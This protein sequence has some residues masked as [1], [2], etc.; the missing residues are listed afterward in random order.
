[1]ERTPKSTRLAYQPALD[2]LRAVAVTMV[3]LFHGGVSWMRGGYFGVSMFFTLSG[4]LITSLLVREFSATQRI[5]PGAFYVRRAKRLLPASTICIVVVSMMAA[6]DVWR[7]ADHIRRDAVGALFQVANWVQ[8]GGGGSYTDLQSKSAGLVSPLD[9]YWSLAI[10][11]QFYWIWPLAF[12]GLAAFARRRGV[13]LT[14]IM[15]ALTAVFAAAA[16]VVAWRWGRDAAYW[17]TPARAAEILIGALLAVAL[18]DGKVTPRRWMAPASLLAVALIAVLLPAAGGPAYHGAFPLLAIAS[19]GLV[20]GV[21][22]PGPVTRALSFKPLIAL[23]AISY[24]VYLYHF[25]I[26]VFLSVARVG[27]SGWVLLAARL[28]V[29]LVFAIASYWLVERP[30]RRAVWTGSRTMMHAAVAIGLVA[31]AILFV[32]T[33]N[34]TYWTAGASAIAAAEIPATGSV[35]PLAAVGP[36]ASGASRLPSSPGLPSASNASSS[37]ASSSSSSSSASGTSGVS[38]VGTSLSTTS[39]SAATSQPVVTSTLA[40]GSE[41]ASTQAPSTPQPGGSTP[42]SVGSAPTTTVDA[43]SSPLTIPVM[44][45][46]NRPVRII[47][48]G[49]S[50]AASTGAGLV[51]WAALD[52]TIAKVTLLVAPGCGF[53]RS[54]VVPTDGTVPYT[55]QCNDILDHQLPDALKT[56]QPDIVM[57]M[58]TIRDVEPRVF[59][60]AEGALTPRDPRFVNRVRGDYVAMTNLILATSSAHVVWIKPPAI[61]PYWMNLDVPQRDVIAHSTMAVLMGA[62]TIGHRDRAIVLDL[63][64]WLETA[65]LAEDHATRPDGIH[66]DQASSLDVATR[67]LGPELVIEATRTSTG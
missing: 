42:S 2:G 57:L 53:I 1:M 56:L 60:S 40:T 8:L 25:P 61:D 59:D 36:Q 4:F 63:G 27:R 9:H 58:T 49:D 38:P 33:R 28:A 30:I 51:E 22:M 5:E 35:V 24:G 50:T 29:T 13:S 41:P 54:G 18:R 6:H 19:C 10:E 14:R 45:L 37:S 31:I 21:Q 20:L 15:V 46:L 48:V 12:W 39:M 52:P 47:V 7:G 65:G 3:L 17:A 32:P 23:G 55:A 62:A 64:A 16:P 66:F 67:W 34:A 26:F 44:P 11:E 43:V